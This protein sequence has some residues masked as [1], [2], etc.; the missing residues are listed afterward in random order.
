MIQ[1]LPTDDSRYINAIEIHKMYKEYLQSKGGLGMSRQND[2]LN[3][4]K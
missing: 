3:R 4:K 1:V 2:H